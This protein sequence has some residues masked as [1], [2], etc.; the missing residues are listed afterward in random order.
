MEDQQACWFTVPV[1]TGLIAYIWLGEAFGLREWLASLLCL[2]GVCLVTQPTALF[3]PSIDPDQ[4]KQTSSLARGY[5]Q[6]LVGTFFGALALVII[7]KIGNRASIMTSL[8][9]FGCIDSLSMLLTIAA[10][11]TR[12]IRSDQLDAVN[13]ALLAG[14]GSFTFPAE[15]S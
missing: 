4:G 1:M 3:A 9:W 5:A 7:R 14:V 11:T 10:D 8:F 15:L 6:A 12:G 13:I 2:I